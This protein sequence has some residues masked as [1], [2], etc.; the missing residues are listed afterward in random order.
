MYTI[1]YLHVYVHLCHLN[2][3]V[4][5][6][7]VCYALTACLYKHKTSKSEVLLALTLYS[8]VAQT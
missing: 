1:V 2:T 7:T 8:S 5:P 6:G 3:I 4:A